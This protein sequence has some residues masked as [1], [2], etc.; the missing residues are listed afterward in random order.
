MKT[1]SWNRF[2]QRINV[3]AGVEDLYTAFATRAG[4]ERWFLRLSEYRHKDGSFLL[5]DENIQPT[6]TY[7]WLWHGWPDSTAETGSFISAN[8]KDELSFSFGNAGIVTVKIYTTSGETIVEL[9][10]DNIPADEASKFTFYVGC[11]TGWV[12]Y[13][14]NLKSIMEGGI[15]LR[16]KNIGL[17][18]VLNA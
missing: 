4:I 2:T 10:Q 12:F 15:D 5:A 6:D 11:S 7:K 1:H 8:G 3:T 17:Q 9:T 14:A 16:N 18:N 13:L